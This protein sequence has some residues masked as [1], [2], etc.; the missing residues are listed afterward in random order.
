[1]NKKLF[2]IFFISASFIL[3]A[4]YTE[5]IN[6]NRPG[7]SESPYSVGTGVYQFEG[8]FFFRDAT[9]TPVFSNPG[10][11]GIDFAFRTSIGI[12]RLE[13]NVNTAF[14]NDKVAFN[15]IFES[16]YRKFGIG[17]L[18][19]GAKYLLFEPTYQD[20]SKEVRSWKKRHA[21]DWK[22]LYPSVAIYGGVNF[23]NMLS[24][25]H[26]RGGITQKLGI[27]LQNEFSQYFNVI[28]NFYFDYVGSQSTQYSLIA[29]A[30]YNFHFRWSAFIEHQ[31]IF[32]NFETKS[33]MGI[34]ATYLFT[35]NLQINTSLR[36]TFE[37]DATGY[38]VSAGVSYRI[39]T[40]QDDY[41]EF[42]EEGN[43]I[44]REG[45]A[46]GNRKGFFSRIFSIFKKDR[47]QKVD[48]K[49]DKESKKTTP[50]KKG[51]FGKLFGGDSKKKEERRKKREQRKLEKEIKKL[52]K[53]L[54]KEDQK[55]NNQ[56]N[57]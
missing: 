24:P 16:S 47:E 20:K 21:F 5:V 52:E 40:H 1:M 46:K 10:A 48:L 35:R 19:V 31:S 45:E 17:K 2:F 11:Y 13:L 51:F 28:T 23:G 30:T 29:T 14:Q 27:L 55:D 15:N 8:N 32:E 26:Q 6:S 43:E 54:E 3:K 33:N 41:K 42:D 53:E 56:N 25:V 38:Y 36:G 57:K 44:T 50:K 12:E 4:Q 18:T 22:R 39:D 34:G 37:Q 9:A 7:F 49:V